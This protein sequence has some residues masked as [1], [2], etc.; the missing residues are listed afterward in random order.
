VRSLIFFL[1]FNIIII[2]ITTTVVKR[3]YFL[4][5]EAG[6]TDVPG[7]ERPEKFVTEQIADFVNAAT[8]VID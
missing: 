2:T 8:F 4:E 7:S 1:L 3:E 5:G 6:M